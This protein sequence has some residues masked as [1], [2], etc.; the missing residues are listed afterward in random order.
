MGRERRQR[1]RRRRGSVPPVRRKSQRHDDGRGHDQGHRDP[2]PL[3][4]GTPVSGNGRRDVREWR[5]RGDQW[6]RVQ[7]ER[8]LSDR[9]SRRHRHGDGRLHRRRRRHC[10]A[11]ASRGPFSNKRVYIAFAGSADIARATNARS[12]ARWDG[13]SSSFFILAGSADIA[14]ATKVRSASRW[15]AVSS[16]ANPSA[17]PRD[18]VRRGH[19]LQGFRWNVRVDRVA[20]V[21]LAAGPRDS[22]RR[23]RCAP[24][25]PSARA[26]P[27][28]R[29]RSRPTR[30]R[31]T[32]PPAPAAL[33]RRTSG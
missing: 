24:R 28:A 9:R 7:R 13:V 4:A 33:C 8:A 30:G 20:L 1:Q 23:D 27:A 16:N 14:R 31:R 26:R 5:W 12:A 25:R 21:G 2:G 3:L 19:A 29:P 15:K 17:P 18:P 32:T 22:R 6:L 10:A 11:T